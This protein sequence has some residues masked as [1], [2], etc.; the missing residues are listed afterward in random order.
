[1][2]VCMCGMVCMYAYMRIRSRT[3]AFETYRRNSSNGLF[4]HSELFDAVPAIT[5]REQKHCIH[6][7]ENVYIYIYIYIYMNRNFVVKRYYSK[8]FN[9]G[10]AQAQASH[11][12]LSVF[13]HELTFHHILV[14]IR[15][16]IPSMYKHINRI[17][18]YQNSYL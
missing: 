3:K 10:H 2:H 4:F 1:M 15:Y 12:Y 7:L 17:H 18:V 9:H 16:S 5:R 8:G 11:T 6:L 14:K 13:A